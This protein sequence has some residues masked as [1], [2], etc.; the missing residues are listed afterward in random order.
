LTDATAF[1][2]MDS[3]RP[4]Y[5]INFPAEEK[6]WEY[7]GLSQTWCER[8]SGNGRYRGNLGCNFLNRMHVSDFE[9][10]TIYTVDP[11]AYTD[12]D[13]T[14]VSE[15]DTKHIFDENNI[16][17]TSLQLDAETGVGNVAEEDPQVML[18]VSKDGGHT[19]SSEVWRSLGKLGHY[20]KRVI[21]RRLGVS[22]DWVFRFR[23]TAPCKRVILGGWLEVEK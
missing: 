10:G 17:I 12:G 18:K 5:H 8:T 22:R 7:D 19:W 20:S 21:W 11:D 2:H 16:S 15:V 23:I 4:L 13:H 9:T 6:S 1:S 3:G 14:I